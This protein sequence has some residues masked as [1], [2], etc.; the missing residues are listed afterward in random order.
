MSSRDFPGT[1]QILVLAALPE[2]GTGST[3]ML[4]CTPQKSSRNPLAVLCLYHEVNARDQERIRWNERMQEIE[5]QEN[6]FEDDGRIPNNPTLPLLVYPQALDSSE[7]DSS[8]CKE[9]LAENGWG[10]RG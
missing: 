8:R 9:L 4:C 2:S 10:R 3:S 5:V 1:A 7:Q 6:V